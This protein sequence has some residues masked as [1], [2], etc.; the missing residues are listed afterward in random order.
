MGNHVLFFLRYLSGPAMSC[1][2]SIP[3]QQ[4]I[5]ISVSPFAPS[6]PLQSVPRGAS[7]IY[8]ESP[9]WTGEADTVLRYEKK[10]LDG[11]KAEMQTCIYVACFIYLWCCFSMEVKFQKEIF[12]RTLENHNLTQKVHLPVNSTWLVSYFAA[13]SSRNLELT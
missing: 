9:L 12:R 8:A 6:S 1:D 2:S 7:S 4:G 3:S 13:C 5:A 10:K 11:H